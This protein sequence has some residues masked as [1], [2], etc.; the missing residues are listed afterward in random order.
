MADMFECNAVR[1]V[2]LFQRSVNDRGTSVN[3]ILPT[4]PILGTKINSLQ[5]CPKFL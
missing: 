2:L 3:Q 4:H 5:T 1:V